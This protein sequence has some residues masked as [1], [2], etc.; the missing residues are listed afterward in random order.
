VAFLNIRDSTTPQNVNV[1]KANSVTIN[2][3]AEETIDTSVFSHSTTTNPGQIT[4]LNNGLYFIDSNVSYD[5]TNSLDV[6]V[7]GS[8]YKNGT[9]IATTTTF[10]YTR[11]A[12]YGDESVQLTTQLELS[13][14]DVIELKAGAD[15]N[16]GQTGNVNVMVDQAEFK[17]SRVSRAGDNGGLSKVSI[18]FFTDIGGNA[19][20][21]SA[22]GMVRSFNLNS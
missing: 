3:T 5:N 15:S 16:Q 2:W 21:S 18:P 1:N 14:G 13:I 8:I 22:F 11:G 12:A 10:S 19:Y 4:I 17:I 9:E 7:A 6:T 20:G